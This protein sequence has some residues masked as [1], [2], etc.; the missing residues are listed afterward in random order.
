MANPFMT[1][2][3]G[4]GT[5]RPLGGEEV[6][7]VWCHV[8]E[9]A[10]TGLP[11]PGMSAGFGQGAAR[12]AQARL[13][14]EQ[15]AAASVE[16]GTLD[17]LTGPDGKVWMVDRA[18]REGALWVLDLTSA[19]VLVSVEIQARARV[20]DGMGG[21][22]TGAW[23]PLA[24]VEGVMEAV[25]G[26]ER[27]LMATTKTLVTHRVRAPYLAGLVEGCRL[28]IAGRYLHVRFV[29]DLY[30][31]GRIMVADCQEMVGE[32]SAWVAT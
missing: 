23:T 32:E 7:P 16:P 26:G 6:A 5:Y 4:N 28:V 20:A 9:D 1:L 3:G 31:Q 25:S 8:V 21:Y 11:S 14:V 19:D 17:R 22:K 30:G 24:T 13:D 2:F 12:Y 18:W 27:S 15:L 29:N 10:A